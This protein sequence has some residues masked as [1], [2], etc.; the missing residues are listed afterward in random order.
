M[1][2][3]GDD[4]WIADSGRCVLQ[5]RSSD[6]TL[7]PVTGQ[8]GFADGTLAAA[9]LCPTGQ[10]A[11]R[12]ATLLVADGGNDTVRIVDPTAGVVRSLAAPGSMV[13]PLGVAVDAA[14]RVVYVA[15][16]GNCVIRAAS[17]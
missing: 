1:F 12:G 6:G 4:L 8:P 2:A 5:R 17:Y 7:T 9:H 16:T 13:H 10:I 11:R 3:D 15:D 14:R